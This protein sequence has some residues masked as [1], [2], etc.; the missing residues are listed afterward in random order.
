[1]LRSAVGLRCSLRCSRQAYTPKQFHSSSIRN[2][3]IEQ[4]NAH[5]PS[6]SF[7]ESVGRPLVL[8]PLLFALGVSGVT[9]YACVKLTNR[10]TEYWRGKLSAA[11]PNWHWLG[12]LPSAVSSAEMRKARVYTFVEEVKK[13]LEDLK[14]ATVGFPNTLRYAI[15]HSYAQVLQFWVNTR[16]GAQLCWKIAALNTFVWCAW[17]VPKFEP[18]MARY[19]LHNPLS[20]LSI[21]LLTSVFS[22]KS[23]VHLAFNMIALSSFGSTA[24]LWME[25]AQSESVSHMQ[26]STAQYH[27]LAYFISAGMFS[28]LVSQIAT[29][30]LRFPR[31][32][33]ELASKAQSKEVIEAEAKGMSRFAML[34]K[35]SITPSAILPSLGASGAIYA[36]VVTT[37]FAFPDTQIG[38]IFPPTPPIS[39]QTGVSALVLLDVIGAL[40]GWRIFDHW[41]HLGGAAFGALYWRYG[42][43]FWDNARVSTSPSP[44][45][46]TEPTS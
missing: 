11:N 31:A 1:M 36:T 17:Q 18:F 8:R 19:F 37:A 13:Q 6:K 43:Y 41:G 42:A 30:R 23:L 10:D 21:G 40:R 28:S 12:G 44:S 14:R 20:G 46:P 7:A 5:T 25:K 3:S 33:K 34:Q 29:S 16:E 45:I 9:Y 27:F 32:I 35:S 38:L 24:F 22:H 15:V 4:A 2:S 39:I 26:E